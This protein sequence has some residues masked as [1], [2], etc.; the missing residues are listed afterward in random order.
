M[1]EVNFDDSNRPR[2][3]KQELSY[4][5]LQERKA[6]LLNE[7]AQLPISSCQQQ[8][9]KLVQDNKIL[10]LVG[11][12]G[13][14]KTTQITQM[15]LHGGLAK[16]GAIACTQPRRVA[17]MSVA[18]RVAEE[19]GT[20]LG[21]SKSQFHTRSQHLLPSHTCIKQARKWATAFDSTTAR[22]PRRKSSTA[23]MA[24]FSGSA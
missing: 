6:A 16:H 21:K 17:A 11:E 4:E 22:A 18:R 10:V 1:K 20:R 13:S 24:C 7:R 5:S 8:I 2:K 12:T 3:R 14:G 23:L 19:M 9:L 15:L